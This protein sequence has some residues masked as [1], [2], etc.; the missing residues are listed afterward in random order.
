MLTPHSTGGGFI[1][2]VVSW[3]IEQTEGAAEVVPIEGAD[4]MPC[5]EGLLPHCLRFYPVDTGTS[6]LFIAKLI[7]KDL[8]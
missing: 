5:S 8:T 4:K 1:E 7:K 2:D 3:L 6:G